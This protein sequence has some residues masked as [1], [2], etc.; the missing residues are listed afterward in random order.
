MS[1]DPTFPAFPVLSLLGAILV[2][3]P[4]PWHLQAW[5]AGTCLYMFWTFVA[6]INLFVNS[7]I[8]H[9]NAINWAPIWC[10][11]SSRLAVGAGVALP[12]ASL[13]IN[14]RLYSIASVKSVTV[15]RADK[16][17]DVIIDLCIGLGIPFIEMVLQVI[18]SA[19]RFDIYEDIGCY[20]VTYNTPPAYALVV[21]WPLAIGLVSSCYC[22]LTLR[23]FFKRRAQFN[24]VIS[25]HSALTVN[26]YFR[27]MAIAM[28]DVV[29]TVPISAFGIYL[30]ASSNSIRRWISWDDTHFNYGEV[31]SIPAILW[32]SSKNGQI[33]VELS[34]W[35]VVFSAFVFFAFFG[36]SMESRKN[37][38][39]VFRAVAKR[40]GVQSASILPGS[41]LGSSPL[42]SKSG[43][44]ASP[45]VSLP[46]VTPP[47]PP[48]AQ[49][50]SFVS[51]APSSD[52]STTATPATEKFDVSFP[53]KDANASQQS[54]PSAAHAV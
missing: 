18:V 45:N 2:I 28:V 47:R 51:F 16:K 52:G 48:R 6:S 30:A 3:V 43:K 27:L 5:N 33:S 1:S 10:D 29:L 22:M 53:G 49:R 36:F 42:S 26:R 37:Y 8:W 38:S 50:V 35:S 21:C 24:E 46:Y 25:A 44:L 32:R 15:T 54:F 13:C 14:R 19:H 31:D 34:R 17:R 20:P 9:D 23:A 4:F 11:I 7:I 12:A 39:R 40:F 41:R